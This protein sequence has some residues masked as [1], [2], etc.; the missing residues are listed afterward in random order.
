MPKV[1]EYEYPQH[2]LSKCINWVEVIFEEN[3][4]RADVLA[5]QLGHKTTDSGAFR[6]KI[7]SMSRYG[8]VAGRGDDLE[9]T[10]L[11][12]QVASPKPGTDER[13]GALNRAAR[14]V[15]ILEELHQRLDGQPLS[16]TGW[17]HVAEVTG[18]DRKEAQDEIK[19]LRKVYNDARSYLVKETE[20]SGDREAGSEQSSE[21]SDGASDPRDLPD[22]RD[23]AE[24]DLGEQ[25]YARIPKENQEDSARRLIAVIRAIAGIED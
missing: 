24:V 14:N 18:V 5:Q 23:F 21:Q 3:I 10:N 7:T 2:G 16:K 20:K 17:H 15:A 19:K 4:S 13:E 22:D 11:G 1:G 6:S 9:L 12:T 8:L 25:G